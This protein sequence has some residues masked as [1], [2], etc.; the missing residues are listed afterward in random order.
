LNYKVFII[1]TTKKCYHWCRLSTKLAA[2]FTSKSHI[3]NHYFEINPNGEPLRDHSKSFATI[4]MIDLYTNT[5]LMKWN[6]RFFYLRNDLT[7]SRKTGSN[8]SYVFSRKSNP[9][10]N[11]PPYRSSLILCLPMGLSNKTFSA[12]KLILY[13]NKLVRAYKYLLK[14]R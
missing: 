5:S 3:A 4:S 8:N 12:R 14:L 6:H 10:V 1:L 11:T 9:F 13:R 7:L 2:I